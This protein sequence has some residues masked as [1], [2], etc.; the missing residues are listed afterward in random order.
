[1]I[2]SLTNS[3]LVGPTVPQPPT[4]ANDDKQLREKFDEFIGQAFFGQM[5]A[6]M[7]KTVGKPAYFHGGRAEEIF[8][9]QLDQALTQELSESSAAEISEPMYELFTLARS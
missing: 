6:A 4:A 2:S 9:G 5:T 7:R 1:M 3:S 8:R